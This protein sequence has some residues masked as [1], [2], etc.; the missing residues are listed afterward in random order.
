M[1]AFLRFQFLFE[2]QKVQI[3]GTVKY[4]GAS[5]QC[6]LEMVI[7]KNIVHTCTSI[8][9]YMHVLSMAFTSMTCTN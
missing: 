7:F 2:I 4:N 1:Y 3:L 8:T 5:N 9:L 6:V